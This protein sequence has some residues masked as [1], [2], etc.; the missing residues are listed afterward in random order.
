MVGLREKTGT[1]SYRI[2]NAVSNTFELI[3]KIITIFVAIGHVVINVS[4]LDILTASF[5]DF[6]SELTFHKRVLMIFVTRSNDHRQ[7]LF[8]NSES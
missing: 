3:F 2:I 6:N 4:G 8:K 7:K 1:L 5:I